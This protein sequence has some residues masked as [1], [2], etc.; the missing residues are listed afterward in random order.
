MRHRKMK[1]VKKDMEDKMTSRKRGRLNINE[2][3][4]LSA[5]RGKWEG[6]IFRRV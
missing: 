4:K 3:M 2:M 1:K 6:N 5:S